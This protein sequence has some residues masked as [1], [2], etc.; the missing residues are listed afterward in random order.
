MDKGFLLVISGPAGVGKG[1]ICDEILKKNEDVIFSIS[2]TTRKPR[3][4][5]VHGEN[6]NFISEED[7]QEMI[8][9]EE[10]IEYA[11]VHTN[12]YG[13]P[14][15]FVE[16]EIKKGKIVLL[17]IDVQGTM[18][19]LEK[20]PEVVTLFLLPPSIEELKRRI[21]DR[22]TEA[23][24]EINKRMENALKEIA[25]IDKYDY[26]VVNNN[27]NLAIE[28]VQ[29]IINAERR[30]VERYNKLSDEYLRGTKC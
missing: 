11:F 10:F 20:Y 26:F 23:E 22:D 15:K 6:Y 18:Q 9:N 14:R 17:E 13:T 27:L 5:E 30:K 8:K 2:S 19:L 24:S 12:Y 16:E 29:E 7:F 25:I 4:G 1:T 28:E 21:I 3:P